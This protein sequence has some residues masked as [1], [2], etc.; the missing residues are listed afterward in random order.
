[1]QD[2]QSEGHAHEHEHLLRKSMP[3]AQ[4]PRVTIGGGN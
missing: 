1:M 3:G 2:E 4:T